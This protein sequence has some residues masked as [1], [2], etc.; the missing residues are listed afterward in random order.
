MDSK[1][2]AELIDTSSTIEKLENDYWGNPPKDS[3]R[4]IT[5]CF[6]LRRKKLLDFE[7]SDFRL[8]IGQNIGLQF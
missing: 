2:I 3:S 1:S 7:L 4:L 5:S 8:L 6:E